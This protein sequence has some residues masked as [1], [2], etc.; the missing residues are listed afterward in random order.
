MLS[1]LTIEEDDPM[2]RL[3]FVLYCL[4]LLAGMGHTRV[5]AG[6]ADIFL[7][8]NQKFWA[9]VATVIL[10]L[11]LPAP[12]D[13]IT[14]VDAI[15]CTKPNASTYIVTLLAKSPITAPR[16]WTLT[17]DDCPKDAAQ[18]AS[19]PRHTSVD[20]AAIF[21]ITRNA[22][23]QRGLLVTA[24][25]VAA[26]SAGGIPS[27]KIEALRTR[28]M[29]AGTIHAAVGG[30]SVEIAPD[31]DGDN[32]IVRVM[33][34]RLSHAIDSAAAISADRPRLG[35]DSRIVASHEAI[36]YVFETHLANREFPIKGS[37]FVIRRAS[38]AA[39]LNSVTLRATIDDRRTNVSLDGTL[40]WNG[41]ELN[42]T[43]MTATSSRQC[44]RVDVV[45]RALRKAED[46][47]ASLFLQE[48]RPQYL[49]K[50]LLMSAGSNSIRLTVA[51]KTYLL[52]FKGRKVTSDANA[53]SFLTNLY[54]WGQ[55]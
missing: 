32:L 21:E 5:Q 40:I 4:V 10:P 33:H 36:R 11:P 23:P 24:K 50:P 13:Q 45:C 18:L 26:T 51:G 19:D 12:H 2:R 35:S 41:A 47:A 14:I 34:P 17:D 37:S 43:S 27:E 3:R 1:T 16:T 52:N 15:S 49:N 28:P 8:L 29:L 31:L 22:P 25:T 9:D 20:A 30:D 44:G 54:V 7:N 42:L 38:Y 55:P 53:L 6:D 48:V 39:G 46:L